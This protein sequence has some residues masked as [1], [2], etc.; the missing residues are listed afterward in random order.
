MFRGIPTQRKS[1]TIGDYQIALD[2]VKD[3]EALLDALIALHPDHPTIIDEQIPYWA[4]LWHSALVLAQ[5]IATEQKQF[6]GKKVLELGCGLGLP[7][8]TAV[9]A[10]AE[11]AF[12]DYLPDALEF[13]AHNLAL[14]TTQAASFFALDWRTPPRH[15]QYDIL[16]AADVAYETRFFEPLYTSI[17]TL[18]KPGGECWLTEPGRPIA[19]AFL[20]GFATHGFQITA[21][22]F[23]VATLD[24]G[25]RTVSSYRIRR[26]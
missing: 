18:L 6:A 15:Q 19:K 17:A 26:V 11:V 25:Q 7:G 12:T 14:N 3:S 16:L 24:G 9:M 5:E 1:F 4:D 23:K 20:K 22:N 10:G 13:A 21:P 2:T 8:I